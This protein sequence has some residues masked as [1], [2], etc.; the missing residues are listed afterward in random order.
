M[1]LIRFLILAAGAFYA[2]KRFFGDSGAGMAET[3]A[4]Q[5]YSS[6]QLGED[7]NPEPEPA[8]AAAAADGESGDPLT[9]PSWLDPADSG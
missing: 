6:E 8:A 9:Q 3:Q 4:A 5:P 1:K 7:G 2:Y